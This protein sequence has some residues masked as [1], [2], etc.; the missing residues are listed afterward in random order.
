[1]LTN[2]VMKVRKA[3]PNILGLISLSLRG[4]EAK[5]AKEVDQALLHSYDNTLISYFGQAPYGLC[6]GEAR[7]AVSENGQELTWLK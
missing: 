2:G 6:K 4:M 5:V 7:R 1:M 3:R